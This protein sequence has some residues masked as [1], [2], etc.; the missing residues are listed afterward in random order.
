LPGLLG[1]EPKEVFENFRE[2]IGRVLNKTVTDARLSLIHKR[3]ST[4]AMLSFRQGDLPTAVP[5]FAKDVFLY[6]GQT[7]RVN[8]EPDKSWKLRTVQ[9]RY[10]VQATQRM[11]D[12]DCFRWEYVAR[13]IRPSQ[14][15][16]HHL[17]LAGQYEMGPHLIPLADVHIPTGW[18]TVEEIIR[19]L[20]TE[21]RVGAKTEDWEAV[22]N[23]SES[24]F[25]QWT[26]REI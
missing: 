5:V 8:Q 10:R 6:V 18:V 16:R 2:H 4:Q 26:S 14:L 23:D 12:D 25:K 15:C 3:G 1:R 24:L 20:I 13:E 11:D 7:L 21:F 9:Y 19:F 22:L 17:H